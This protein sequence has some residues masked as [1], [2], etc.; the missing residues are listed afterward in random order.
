MWL[1]HRQCM[2]S[3]NYRTF[4]KSGIVCTLPCNGLLLPFCFSILLQLYITYLIFFYIFNPKVD[5]SL[6]TNFAKYFASLILKTYAK[7][8][9]KEAY[10][11]T[12][13]CMEAGMVP[14]LLKRS[15][16]IWAWIL[17]HQQWCQDGAHTIFF[18]GYLR[19]DWPNVKMEYMIT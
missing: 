10:L 5:L 6:R 1:F 18:Y 9:M 16:N 14:H 4:Q 17:M 3:L 12:I 8:L 2:I 7:L 15:Y 11:L 19:S 13:F